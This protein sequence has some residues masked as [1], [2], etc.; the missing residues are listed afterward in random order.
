MQ[1]FSEESERV[2]GLV[3]AAHSPWIH[4]EGPEE[5]ST[6]LRLEF[7]ARLAELATHSRVSSGRVLRRSCLC[8]GAGGR[9]GVSGWVLSAPS[10]YGG[11]HLGS[12]PV[13]LS[14]LT[15]VYTCEAAYHSGTVQRENARIRVRT[16]W[17]N[18]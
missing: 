9:R 14:E 10:R 11:S 1:S 15:R 4:A 3:S 7:E 16:L 17:L 12:T 2:M 6:E 13:P 5:E 18:L 8:K